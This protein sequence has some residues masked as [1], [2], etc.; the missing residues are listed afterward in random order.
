ML[1]T[2]LSDI[3]AN[4]PAL[5]AVL[6]DARRYSPDAFVVAGDL[7]GG[8]HPTETLDLL[9]D[10]PGWMI[11]GNGESYLL[12]FWQGDAPLEWQTQ[13][14]FG[15]MRWCAKH[16]T[17][18][19]RTLITRLP[20]D[21]A[22][23][24]PGLAPI[25]LVHGSPGR[26][27][28]GLHPATRAAD[29]ADVL[30]ALSEPVLVCG[31]THEQWQVT[32]DGHL[33]VNPGAVCGPCDG[34]VG[35]QYALLMWHGGRWEVELK[36]VEYD[37]AEVRQAFYTNGL[38]EEGGPFARAVLAG[39]ETGIDVARALLQHA[40]RYWKTLGAGGATYMSDETW[41]AAAECFDWQ[42]YERGAQ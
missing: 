10:L 8:P 23:Y 38:L 36:T 6:T 14:Q 40:D 17:P 39:I 9:A 22:I 32:V 11:R 5:Q 28:G 34:T 33:A 42:R 4:L 3:H 37:I 27:T 24:P 1:L 16:V 2:L 26:P 25:R 20:E 35:A 18:G 29:F 41:E 15:F 12:R 19:H 13:R 21:L 7:S 31:H 30:N